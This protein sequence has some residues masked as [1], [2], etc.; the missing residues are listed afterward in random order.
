MTSDWLGG[1]LI[2]ALAAVLWLIYLIPTWFRRNEFLSTERNVVRLQQTLRILAETSEVPDEVHVEANARSVAE[3]QRILKK[4][5]A[6]NLLAERAGFQTLVEQG[7]A[8][9]AASERSALEVARLRE[10]LQ[11]ARGID[12]ATAAFD[13]DAADQTAHYEPGE[14]E[15]IVITP[16]PSPSALTLR[17]AS[18]KLRRARAATSGILLLA[19]T[20][21][22][23]GAVQTAV[24]GAWIVL[25]VGVLAA[26]L[27]VT[28]LGRLARE[29]RQLRVRGVSAAPASA[30]TVR[31]PSAAWTGSG[32]IY[33]ADS[34]D[35]AVDD[36]AAHVD[37]DAG[38]IA[39]RAA[40]SA[41]SAPDVVDGSGWTPVPLPKPLYVGNRRIDGGDSVSGYVEQTALRAEE[42]LRVAARESE[43]ALRAAQAAT[44]ARGA[45]AGAGSGEDA[46][47]GEGA[48]AASVA[49]AHVQAPVR[50]A[51]ASRFASMG[52]IDGSQTGAIDVDQILARRRAG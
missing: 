19:L 3:Q 34:A 31:R 51:A 48:G 32:S 36:V 47:S 16:T 1:G 18:L 22:V 10:Q 27:C 28:R 49:E 43:L 20:V 5:N 35:L 50:P 46:G 17:Q 42:A 44:D 39:P 37:A 30:R 23:L 8:A 21:T 6:Q 45:G 40:G 29:V 12:E 38:L 7:I 4:A 15:T 33:D 25:V 2:V 13:G 41:N 26:T 24:N 14:Y 52:V 11:D 9:Q